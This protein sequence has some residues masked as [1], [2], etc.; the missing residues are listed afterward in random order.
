MSLRI[1]SFCLFLG[2]FFLA[3]SQDVQ[4]LPK[5]FFDAIFKSVYSSLQIEPLELTI[6]GVIGPTGSEIVNA[7]AYRRT[8]LD[9]MYDDCNRRH[10]EDGGKWAPGR[11]SITMMSS[12]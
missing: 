2:L 9:S 7:D 6:E 11:P 10:R 5:T 3:Q 12:K 1:C 4:V 8:W